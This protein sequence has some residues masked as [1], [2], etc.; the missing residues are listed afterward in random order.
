MTEEQIPDKLEPIDIPI[1][2]RGEISAFLVVG[3]SD[4]KKRQRFMIYYL[5]GDGML[6]LKDSKTNIG[7]RNVDVKKGDIICVWANME[8]GFEEFWGR[9]NERG[10]WIS[11]VETTHTLPVRL[12]KRIH[13]WCSKRHINDKNQNSDRKEI[14]T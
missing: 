2:L 8:T 14:D 13:N 11:N 3:S 5:L 4:L 7:S 6:F 9:L 1:T 10:D 12:H